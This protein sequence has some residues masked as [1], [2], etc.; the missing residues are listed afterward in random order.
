MEGHRPGNDYKSQVLSEINIVELI[1]KSVSLKKRGRNYVGLCPFHQE[2]TR[3]L[4]STPSS[5]F[6]TA[7]AVKRAEMRSTS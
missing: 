4:T 2:K 7:L 3:R 1:G 6:F 5:S